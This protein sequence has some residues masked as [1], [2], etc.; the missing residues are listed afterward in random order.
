MPENDEPIELTESREETLDKEA[1]K[2]GA[3][4][5]P[6]Q[7]FQSSEAIT[8]AFDEQRGIEQVEHPTRG[9]KQD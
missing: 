1:R 7:K 2:L 5:F 3:L 4:H 6:Y 8:K 9:K